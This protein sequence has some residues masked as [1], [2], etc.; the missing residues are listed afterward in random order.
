MSR[1]TT[2]L[3]LFRRQSPASGR[4][5]IKRDHRR[6]ARFV[7]VNEMVQ[8]FP[9]GRHYGN[10]VHLVVQQLGQHLALSRDIVALGGKIANLHP[11]RRQIKS[12]LPHALPQ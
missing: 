6:P 10:A 12:G 1:E 7:F 9:V 11:E 2:A 3:V 8:R 5:P 4:I